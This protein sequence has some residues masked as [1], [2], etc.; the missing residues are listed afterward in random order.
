[1]P[2]GDGVVVLLVVL[3]EDTGKLLLVA[4]LFKIPL[5][6]LLQLAEHCEQTPLLI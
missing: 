5:E 4:V 6:Q 3:V 1:V 2:E